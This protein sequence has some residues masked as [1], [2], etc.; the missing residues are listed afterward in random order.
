MTILVFIAMDMKMKYNFQVN[1]IPKQELVEFTQKWHYSPVF[2][3][4]T[5]HWLGIYDDEYN[6]VGTLTL[7]WGTQP[8]QTIKKLFPSLDTN[9]YL[10]IGKMCMDDKMPKNSETQMLK[11]VVRWIKEYRPDV[12]LLY[13]MADGIMGKVGYVYQAFN[14]K[15]G[16]CYWTDVFMTSTGEKV[17]PRSMKDILKENAKFEG[18]EK[19]FWATPAYMDTIGMSRI[20]G[21]MFRYMYALNKKGKKLL[22]ESDWGIDYPKADSL[23][24][25]K[26]ISKGKYA[27]V[28]MPKFSYENAVVNRKNI[29]QYLNKS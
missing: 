7:G 22:K 13:T 27:F 4:L 2:P 28:D 9:D 6:L 1:E 15:Y 11:A 24:W 18:K 25:K 20:R 26:Q 16:G 5:K 19:L 8:K 10:E 23:K 17:H 21:Y 14:F 12:S 29:D 3:K